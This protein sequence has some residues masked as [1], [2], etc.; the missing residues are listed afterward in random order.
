MSRTKEQWEA[1]DRQELERRQKQLNKPEYKGY[2]WVLC[3][4]IGG[5]DRY[6]YPSWYGI[7]ADAVLQSTVGQ[8]RQ[9]DIHGAEYPGILPRYDHSVFFQFDHRISY[10]YHHHHILYC[11]CTFRNLPL[12]NTAPRSTQ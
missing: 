1:K 11:A 12:P 4:V 8:V 6:L 5:T 9:E 3:V 2:L 7:N 10:R